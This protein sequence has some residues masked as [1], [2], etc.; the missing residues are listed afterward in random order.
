MR[1]LIIDDERIARAELRR[2]LSAHPEIEISG[3]ARN[4][5]EALALIASLKPEV[6]FLDIQ[7]PGMSGF[8][9]LEQLDDA[10]QVIFTTAFDKHAL[11]AFEANALDYLLKPVAAPRLAT[12][13]R[14]LRHRKPNT[15]QTPETMSGKAAPLERVFVRDGDRCWLVQVDDIVLLESE[16]NYTRLFFG[17]DKPLIPRSL[18]ALEERLDPAKFFR[19]SRQHIVNLRCIEQVAPGVADNLIV[20]VKGGHQIEMSRRQSARLREVLSF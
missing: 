19:A 9:L 1:A 17:K 20:S 2:L 18:T 13:I 3:E 11:Q 14:K 10:P 4:G 7:M 5:P 6:I 15:P 8:E 12:A 16:G